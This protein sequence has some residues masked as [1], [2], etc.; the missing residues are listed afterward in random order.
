MSPSDLAER[1]AARVDARPG[2]PA[3][4]EIKAG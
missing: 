1:F 3:R 4:D 2:A